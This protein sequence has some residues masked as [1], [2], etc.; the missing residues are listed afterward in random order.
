MLRR[1][2][3]FAIAGAV[4]FAVSPTSAAGCP[5]DRDAGPDTL[6]SVRIGAQPPVRL[7]RAALAALPTQQS[8]QRRT[9]ASGSSAPAVEQQ[10]AY[11]G[12]PLAAIVAGAVS[13]DLHG[14]DQRGWMFDAVA[15][16][17]YRA[18]FSWGELFNTD[19]G[20]QVL[21]IVAQD[22]RPLDA[23]EGPLALRALADRRPGPRHVRNLCAILVRPLP[24][25]AR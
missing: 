24:P 12:V 4:A 17:G 18:L 25:A 22:G 14:R 8:V 7:D 11:T 19:A 9:V 21:V 23:R 10:I 2:A 1:T 15:T 6:L 13:D 20:E 16:D 3:A 5:G